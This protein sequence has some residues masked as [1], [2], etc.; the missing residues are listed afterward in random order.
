MK[1]VIIN[2]T[3]NIKTKRTTHGRVWV[4]HGK[5]V[6]NSMT[7]WKFSFNCL[8]RLVYCQRGKPRRSPKYKTFLLLHIT[9][10]FVPG[11]SDFVW[12]NHKDI[13]R[14]VRLKFVGC[15]YSKKLISQMFEILNEILQL[16]FIHFQTVEL[17]R[18]VFVTLRSDLINTFDERIPQTKISK[19]DVKAFENWTSLQCNKPNADSVLET[20][21]NQPAVQQTQRW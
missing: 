7:W 21:M 2:Q 15:K 14:D 19:F 8:Y 4:L 1:V 11:E 13:V 9:I 18:T 10:Q 6:I 5:I 20:F 3:C 17:G 12:D 16:K